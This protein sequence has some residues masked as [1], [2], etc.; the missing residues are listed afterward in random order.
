MTSKPKYTRAQYGEFSSLVRLLES[1]AQ[2]D[3][4]R[5]RLAMP[6][7]MEK[8]GGKE[9]CDAMFEELKKEKI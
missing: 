2:L 7:F 3:R 6:K 9:V 5:G 4:I 1:H 8:V